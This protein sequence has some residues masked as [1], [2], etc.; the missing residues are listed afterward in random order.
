MHALENVIAL[1]AGEKHGYRFGKFKQ[2]EADFL[3]HLLGF[4]T[5]AEEKSFNQISQEQHYLCTAAGSLTLRVGKKFA[6]LLRHGS[7]HT[8]EMY[9]NGAADMDRIFDCCRSDVHPMEQ[10][11]DGRLF[12]SFLQGNSKR[13]FFVEVY[14]KDKWILGEDPLP[15]TIYIGCTQGHPTGIVQPTESSHKFSIVELFA[16][17][18]IFHVTDQRYEKSIYSKGSM[19]YNRD[20]LLLCM[21]MMDNL[22]TFEK[23]Q[24][25]SLQDNMIPQGIVF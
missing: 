10:Y 8:K 15:W 9:P 24:E 7:P 11:V 16:C 21:T 3:R 2:W 12:A 22:A 4:T 20:S 18:W 14:L 5:F 1:I 19:R 17:G 6:S 23:E 25:Q 13:R